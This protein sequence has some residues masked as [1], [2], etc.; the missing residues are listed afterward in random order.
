MEGGANVI[1]MWSQWASQHTAQ[2]T[3]HTAQR[4]MHK[5]INSAQ[6]TVNSELCTLHTAVK[7]ITVLYCEEICT[8]Y[9]SGQSNILQCSA[10]RS[11]CL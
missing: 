5:K 8:A 9:S 6:C 11:W 10:I 1:L 7:N 4:T 3:V 2:Y